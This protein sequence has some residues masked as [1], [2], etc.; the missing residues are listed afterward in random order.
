MYTKKISKKSHTHISAKFHYIPSHCLKS[1]KN[2]L[3]CKS[4]KVIGG[5]LKV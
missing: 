4:N 5:S 2:T 1:K 3:H